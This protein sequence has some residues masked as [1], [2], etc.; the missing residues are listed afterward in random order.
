MTYY[1][2]LYQSWLKTLGFAESSQKSLPQY[3][4]EMLV[5]FEEKEFTTAS[6]LTA[7]SIQTYFHQWKQRKNKT[8]GAGLSAAHINKG[9]LAIN[10]FVKFLNS[11]G[12][13]RLQ[14]KL[15]REQPN[16]K[17][18]EVLTREEIASLYEATYHLNKRGNNEAFG[19]RDR[20]MLAIYYGCGLRRSEGIQLEIEDILKEK[21]LIHVR[22][23]KGGKERY[24][25]VT[26]KGMGDIEEYISYGRK[27][28]LRR[29]KACMGVFLVNMRGESMQEFTP[30]LKALKDLAGIERAFSLHSLRH[31]IA[32]H[33]LQGGMEIEWIRKFLGHSSL[34]STQLYTHILNEL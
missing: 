21:K 12:K 3:V 14:V 22:K 2:T 33:L 31:S 9:V 11:T 23:G 34:E 5:Y 32:T 18:P 17:L 1:L 8:T 24:V 28:F 13:A 16:G 27:W 30:R 10:N 6:Q 4:K 20:A 7:E 19:Q 26:D 25:P 29:N 15:E